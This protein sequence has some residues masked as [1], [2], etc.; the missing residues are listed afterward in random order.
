VHLEGSLNIFFKVKYAILVL[1]ASSS[2]SAQTLT[3]QNDTANIIGGT[4]VDKHFWMGLPEVN[5]DGCHDIFVGSH[6]E[7]TS[8][9]LTPSAMYLQ[10]KTAEGVCAN[11]FTYLPNS[12]SNYSQFNP[13]NT[14]IT[15]RFVFEDWYADPE[16]MLSFCG[17]DVDGNPSACYK[18]DPASIAG[19]TVQYLQ[20]V[21]GCFGWKT[22]T[23]KSARNFCYPID[24]NGDSGLEK[25]VRS[26]LAGNEIT[27]GQ[28]IDITTGAKLIQPD[29]SGQAYC[30]MLIAIDADNDSLPEIVSPC[31][32]GYWKYNAGSLDWIA[33]TLPVLSGAGGNHYGVIDYNAD[34]LM[35]YYILMG[36]YNANGNVRMR[37][38]RNDGG[39]FSDQSASVGFADN[40]LYNKSYWTTYGNSKV[41]D[42]YN[43][44]YPDIVFASEIQNTHSSTKTSV[45]IIRND[46]GVFTVDRSM[47]FGTHLKY[48]GDASRPWVDVADYNNDG[49]LDIA[50]THSGFSVG[51][52]SNITPNL[53]SYIKLFLRGDGT[54]TRGIGTKV[55]AKVED[56]VISCTS[57]WHDQ[58]IPHLGIGNNTLVDIEV[59]WPGLAPVVY[60]NISSNSVFILYETGQLVPYIPGNVIPRQFL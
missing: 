26:R 57:V 56:V 9:V 12:L 34:G 49:K 10:D 32:G 35:D 58:P 44:G 6:A 15:S 29:A 39:T 54:N 8:G 24:I 2:L 16:G 46:A 59:T 27:I 20:K 60:T 19:G 23:I 14:R 40:L 31:A 48:T 53:G 51:I 7:V 22:P 41:A 36:I 42:L 1:L 50:K 25:Y 45:T 55:C 3:W 13:T 28:I 30:D 47:N 5:A 43:D 21:A 38:Y 4:T 37:M 11:T 18:I 33:N 52:F 17:H